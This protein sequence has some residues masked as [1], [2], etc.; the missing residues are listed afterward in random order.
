MTSYSDSNESLAWKRTPWVTRTYGTGAV[1]ND[2][3]RLTSVQNG[4][5][6][7]YYFYNKLGRVKA[8]VSGVNEYDRGRTR[9]L[10]C[11]ARLV[12]LGWGSGGAV[13]GG[14]RS[15]AFAVRME[16]HEGLGWG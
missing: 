2:V 3:G 14:G 8:I 7:R 10:A 12:D 6:Y 13:A 1:A 9:L 4:D 16:R 15:L 11:A 5:N